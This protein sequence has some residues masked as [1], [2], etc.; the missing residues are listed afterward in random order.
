MLT[1]QF[2]SEQRTPTLLFVVINNKNEIYLMFFTLVAT[3]SG[4][5]VQKIIIDG[6]EDNKIGKAC[7][8]ART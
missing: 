1:K 3:M 8:H 2:T 6:Q 5:I 7:V 4:T